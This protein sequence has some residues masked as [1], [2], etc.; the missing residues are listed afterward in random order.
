MKKIICFLLILCFIFTVGCQ[1]SVQLSVGANS[2]PEAIVIELMESCKSLNTRKMAMC[3]DSTSKTE[4][5]KYVTFMNK[6]AFVDYF[7]NYIKDNASIIEYEIDEVEIKDN[8]ATVTVK[9]KYRDIGT[10]FYSSIIEAMSKVR[11]MER[12]GMQY[13]GKDIAEIVKNYLDENNDEIQ[14][15]ELSKDILY[16]DCVN[17]SGKWYINTFVQELVDL[18]YSD[19]FSVALNFAEL[20]ND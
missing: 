7:K 15:E 2:S 17:K 20:A 1:S 14:N 5:S 4:F 16:I 11:S 18:A 3:M 6:N 10:Y 9:V 8:K 19:T 12:T 13:S